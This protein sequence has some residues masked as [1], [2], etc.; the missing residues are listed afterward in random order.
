MASGRKL[1]IREC[2]FQLDVTE[3]IASVRFPCSFFFELKTANG[4]HHVASNHRVKANKGTIAFQETVVLNVLMVYD[5]KQEKYKKKEA[6][7]LVSLLSNSRPN[8]PKLVG[9]VTLDLSEVAN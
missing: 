2:N 6:V 4:K 8:D 5:L 7:I 3:G 1:E 9:R